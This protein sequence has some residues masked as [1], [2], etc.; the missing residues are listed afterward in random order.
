MDSLE[1]HQLWLDE[2]F[3]HMNTVLEYIRRSVDDLKQEHARC[4]VRCTEEMHHHNGRLR[5]LE[6]SQAALKGADENN[7]RTQRSDSVTWQMVV[8]VATA[9]SALG[10]CLSYVIGKGP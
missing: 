9:L 5:E 1:T 8:A 10:V 6:H 3:S 7:R 2:R 4:A